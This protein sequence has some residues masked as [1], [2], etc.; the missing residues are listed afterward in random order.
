MPRSPDI[1]RPE[2]S[3]ILPALGC[4]KLLVKDTDFLKECKL[5]T[6]DYNTDKGPN[7]WGARA[8]VMTAADPLECSAPSQT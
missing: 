1:S 2:V 8:S 6:C 7:G 4:R 3:G 5:S